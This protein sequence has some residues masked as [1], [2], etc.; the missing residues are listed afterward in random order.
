MLKIG[1]AYHHRIHRLNIVQFIIVHTSL[2]IMPELSREESLALLSALLPDIRHR[3]D[4]KIHFLV[5]F[6][7]GGNMVVSMPVRKAYHANT[8]PVIGADDPAIAAGP[9]TQGTHI[10]GR[11]GHRTLTNK[12]SARRCHVE[13]FY[14]A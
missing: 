8:H 7:K 4:I 6:Q 11:T 12:F 14:Q 2:D 5:R 10:S 3:D 9:K 1:R 13:I